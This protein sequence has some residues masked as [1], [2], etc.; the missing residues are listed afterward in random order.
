VTQPVIP[1]DH[2]P[3]LRDLIAPVEPG[4]RE[5]LRRAKLSELRQ[6]IEEN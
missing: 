6:L 4:E 2:A 3:L 5:E 1:V